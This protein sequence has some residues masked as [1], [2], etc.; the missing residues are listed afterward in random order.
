MIKLSF[1]YW[2]TL[3][4]QLI[5]I[6]SLLAGFSLSLIFSLTE[7]KSKIM[8]YI[9]RAATT[10]TAS[11][12]VVIFAMTKIL[13]LTNKG[14]PFKVTEGN[15]I[16]PRLIGITSFITGILSIIVIISLSGWAKAENSK[17]FTTI[18]GVITLI[19]IIAMI[20]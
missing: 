4:S 5:V 18:I 19:L 11:F 20:M 7:N 8:N 9:F 2:N 17:K 15:L 3:A 1:E 6:S 16:F 10:A 13:M 12:L 14:F